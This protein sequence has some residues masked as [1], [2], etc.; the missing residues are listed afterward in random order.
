MALWDAA[1]KI[2]GLGGAE[3][4]P[5]CFQPFGGY[6]NETTIAAGAAKPPVVPGIGFELKRGL[7]HAFEALLGG[8][9][10]LRC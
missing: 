7:R 5:L 10:S 8:D 3:V 1:A 4:N 2:L 6:G 9:P